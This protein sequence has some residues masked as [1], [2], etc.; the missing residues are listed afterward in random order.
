VKTRPAF[1]RW[2]DEGEPIQPVL[3]VETLSVCDDLDALMEYAD[4]ATHGEALA[5]ITAAVADL[6]ADVE[7]YARDEGGPNEDDQIH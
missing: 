4:P 5:R 6:R 1:Q 2:H 3:R 7:R